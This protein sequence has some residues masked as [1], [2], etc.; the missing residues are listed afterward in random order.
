MTILSL[1]FVMSV[2]FQEQKQFLSKDEWKIAMKKKLKAPDIVLRSNGG[3]RLNVL[4]Q[5]EVTISQGNH[6]AI[7]P[8]VLLYIT[9]TWE[10]VWTSNEDSDRHNKVVKTQATEELKG[11][12]LHEKLIHMYQPVGKLQSAKVIPIPW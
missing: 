9:E 4:A 7:S 2:L 8:K 1:K 11:K 6:I 12:S 5:L 10:K 3:E